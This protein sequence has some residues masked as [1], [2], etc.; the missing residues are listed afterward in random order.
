MPIGNW[1]GH[2]MAQ[3]NWYAFGRLAWDHRLSA[4]TIADEWIR[5]TWS[6][7]PDVVATISAMMLDSREAY[8]DYTMPL[9]LHH[10]IGGDHYAPMPENDDAPR[11][12]W[13]ATYYHRADVHGLGFDRTRAGSGAVDQYHQPLSDLWNDLATCPEEYLLWFH[14]LAWDY[15]LRSG[16]TLWDELVHRYDRGARRANRLEQEW[17]S[18][19]GKVDE[20][21]H[22]AVARKMR[23]QTLDAQR[24]R[25]KCLSYFQ[26]FS[27]R[28]YP[29][30]PSTAPSV[31]E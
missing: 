26:L 20:E 10:L 17:Q 9:G 31:A 12:D 4:E 1:C 13:T 25:E 16:R 15:R 11:A 27:K 22:Q 5:M 7:E 14:R 6:H 2:P 23:Q 18:L 24:W 19:S 29:S 3:A 21:R 30:R 28:S 8:V